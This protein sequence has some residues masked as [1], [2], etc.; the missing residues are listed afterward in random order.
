MYRN[1]TTSR[2]QKQDATLSGAGAVVRI[3][4]TLTHL[5]RHFRS[6]TGSMCRYAGS[7]SREL[8]MVHAQNHIDCTAYTH[9]GVTGGMAHACWAW[10]KVTA[11]TSPTY[12]QVK[13]GGIFHERRGY[14]LRVISSR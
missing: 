13:M 2:R 7:A 10:K 8:Q 12:G 9:G 4:I 6:E 14:P 3:P 5:N 11:D 1:T